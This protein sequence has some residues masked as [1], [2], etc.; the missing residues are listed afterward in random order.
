[1]TCSKFLIEDPHP[2]VSCKPHCHMAFYA[3]YVLT[4]VRGG[5]GDPARTGLKMLETT[6]L[7]LVAQVTSNQRCVCMFPK[8][9]GRS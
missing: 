8:E 1:M 5:G 2:G 6:E 9:K 3:C 7:N 4:D